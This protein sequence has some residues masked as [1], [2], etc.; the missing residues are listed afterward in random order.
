MVDVG[1]EISGRDFN[2]IIDSA[3]SDEFGRIEK[4]D[5]YKGDLV[6]QTENIEKTFSPVRSDTNKHNFVHK[7]VYDNPC[8]VR[9]EAFSSANGRQYKCF[10]NPIWLL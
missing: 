7:I 5:L 6:N 3:S 8:Y 9:L 2:L 1:G 4:I 10:S